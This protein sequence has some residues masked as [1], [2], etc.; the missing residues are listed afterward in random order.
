MYL[1]LL[2]TLPYGSSVP[3]FVIDFSFFTGQ[4]TYFIFLGLWFSIGIVGND[5]V[6]HECCEDK[7]LSTLLCS[8]IYVLNKAGEETTGD[9]V[10]KV[11]Q[12]V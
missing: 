2:H 4:V 9:D 6:S 11:C 5:N 1:T 12:K 8:A 10:I 7:S 3:L